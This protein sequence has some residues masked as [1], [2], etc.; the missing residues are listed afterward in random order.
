MIEGIPP[1]GVLVFLD[2]YNDRSY[3]E[4]LLS[5]GKKIADEKGV[6][7]T[8]LAINYDCNEKSVYSSFGPDHM[9]GVNAYSVKTCLD[10]V[11]TICPYLIIGC[12]N[13]DNKTTLAQLAI[14][15]ECGLV[16]DCVDIEYYDDELVF[17]R[18]A[19]NDSV[20][21]DI[22]CVNSSYSACTIKKG[23]FSVCEKKADTKYYSINVEKDID[24]T[25]YALMLSCK[26]LSSYSP[27]ALNT[28]ITIGAGRGAI[29]YMD[30]I[31]LLS[32]AIGAELAVSRPL[33]DM[34][35]AR[36]E[37]QIGQSGRIA[38]T[39]IYIALGISGAIQHIV[40]LSSAKTVIAVNSDRTAPIYKYSDYGVV[41]DIGVFID[42]LLT[43]WRI[44]HES[45]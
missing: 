28:R 43:D 3:N 40:G 42:K 18:T 22:K 20:I 11:R 39:D 41:E 30:K 13:G 12:C 35:I 14:E 38:D 9:I 7:L 17:S 8:G 36:K 33:V 26:E 15:L 21:A 32:D 5:I 24:E 29:K 44:N 2:I 31:R 25:Q 37:Q 4:Q 34:G 27:Q 10:I 23:C 1:N 19:A 6:C 16:A 45:Y